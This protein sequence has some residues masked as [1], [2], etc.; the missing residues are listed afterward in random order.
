MRVAS[1]AQKVLIKDRSLPS[2]DQLVDA[3]VQGRFIGEAEAAVLTEAGDGSLSDLCAAA[4]QLR[5]QGKGTIV[6]FSPK[7]FIPLTRLCR[8][9]CGYCTFRQDPASAG[10]KLF[11]TPEEVLEVA[12]AGQRLGCKEGV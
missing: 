3:T 7:V 9:Y 1:F 11:M 12:R 4:A 2:L 10:G 8:D 6:T 5:D